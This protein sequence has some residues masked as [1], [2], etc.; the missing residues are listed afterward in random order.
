MNPVQYIIANPA[1]KLSPG[2]LAAQVAHASVEGVRISAKE[3]WGNPWDTTLVN[4]WYRGGHYAKIVLQSDDLQ[5][6]KEYI[7]AR[8]FKTALIIDE[9]RTE[10]EPMTPTALGVQIV[11]KD[12]QHV[13]DTFGGFKLYQQEAPAVIIEVGHMTADNL[14]AV[15]AL[16]ARGEYK[17]AR[18]YAR[19][20]EKPDS[21]IR[22]RWPIF[23]GRR[24]KTERANYGEGPGYRL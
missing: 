19:S 3:P 21:P 8:G 17:K 23:G 11:D 6:A 24:S 9:G 14:E 12:C 1:L 20:V 13:R 5:I 2:K 4:L 22:K 15:R 10:I 7:E 16:V 18:L